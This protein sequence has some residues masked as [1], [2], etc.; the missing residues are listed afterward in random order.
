MH[1]LHRAL[2]LE[3]LKKT[4]VASKGEVGKVVF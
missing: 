3:G 1:V 2:R 4:E